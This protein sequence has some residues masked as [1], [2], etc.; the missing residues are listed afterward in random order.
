MKKI[1]MQ[2]LVEV[3]NIE[4]QEMIATSLPLS[5]DALDTD[6]AENR[7]EDGLFGDNEFLNV[8]IK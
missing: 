6:Q 2:P 1:Y 3:E 8:L 4:L 7:L 5:E